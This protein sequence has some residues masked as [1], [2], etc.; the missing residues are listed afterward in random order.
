[1]GGEGG[2]WSAGVGGGCCMRLNCQ[3]CSEGTSHTNKH[4]LDTS[5]KRGMVLLDAGQRFKCP[6]VSNHISLATP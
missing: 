1:M 6:M 5:G 2:G 3:P 4:K